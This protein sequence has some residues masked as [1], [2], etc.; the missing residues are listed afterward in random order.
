MCDDSFPGAQPSNF[1]DDDFP[2]LGCGRGMSRAPR[3]TNS[4]AGKLSNYF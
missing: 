3:N 4:Y 1:D 2:A